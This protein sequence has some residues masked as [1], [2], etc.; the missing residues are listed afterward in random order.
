MLIERKGKEIAMAYIAQHPEHYLNKAVGTG[1]CVALVQA[2]SNAPNTGSWRAGIKVMGSGIGTIAKGTVIATMVD[3][4]YPNHKHGNHAAIYLSH[5]AHGIQVIDQ[6]HGQVTHY[7]TIHDH[8][9]HGSPSNDA[10]KFY[11][12]E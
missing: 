9:D 6:W 7:R 8:G 5:D 12:V 4:H 3:G 11:V 2:A 10:S 1:E